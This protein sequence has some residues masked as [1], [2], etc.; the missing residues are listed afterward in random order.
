MD[1]RLYLVT[2]RRLMRAPSIESAVKQAILGGCTMVQLREKNISAAEYYAI[3]AR[4][5]RVTSQYGVPLIINDRADIAA[6]ADAAGVH[7]GQSDLPAKAA[8]RVVGLRKIVGV[9]VDCAEQAL[10]AQK[11]G[12]DYL[13]VTVF[14]TGTKS[15]TSVVTTAELKRIT[16]AVSIP[17]VAIGGINVSTLPSLEAT[18][19]AG[20]SVVS[21][22]LS[23]DDI[24][25]AARELKEML[26]RV[27]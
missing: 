13:G 16:S 12:A 1:Y 21:A 17:V 26:E 10:Q 14:G 8:R 19:I 23:A 27:I 22:I 2:D 24:G 20:I 3:A 15:D 6:A 9:S 7:V 11:D 4:V 5:K 25:R 18:G